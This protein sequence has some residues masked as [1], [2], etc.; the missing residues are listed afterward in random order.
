MKKIFILLFMTLTLP[1]FSQSPATPARILLGSCTK[2]SL[3]QSPFATWFSPGYGAYHPNSAAAA[4]LSRK[5]FSGISISLYFGSWCG[6]SRRE[7]PRFLK[8]LDS[9][10]FPSAQLSLFAVGS[11][12]SLYKQTPSHDEA[13][14]GIF[15]VPTIVI[16]RN[17]VEMN[18]ITE[19]PVYSLEKDL[20]QILNGAEYTSNYHSFPTI[21][22]WMTNGAF[23]DS[24]ISARSLAAQLTGVVTDEHE[25]NSLGYVLLKQGR[26]KEAL[27]IFQ[28]NYALFPGSS[29]IASSLGEGY[30]ENGDYKKA[31]ALLE[32]SIELNKDPALVNDLLTLWYKAKQ[33]E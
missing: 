11:S 6:D 13:G 28:V 1:G 8:L 20:L 33:K 14:K 22:Q 18:R 10:S 7:V 3:L 19:Y 21:R 17:G 26:K 27:K 29:N 2:D 5:N 25:L 12:D 23:E 9:I 4:T 24:N 30:Y 31:I 15:R 32:Q 16:Y